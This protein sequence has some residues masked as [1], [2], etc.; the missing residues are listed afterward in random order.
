MLRAKEKE[1]IAKLQELNAKQQELSAVHLDV[2]AKELL[3]HAK[4]QELDAKQEE[5]SAKDS[6]LAAKEATVDDLKDQ[7]TQVQQYRQVFVIGND[8]AL[9][10]CWK[11]R[12]IALF[13][14][15]GSLLSASLSEVCQSAS[16]SRESSLCSGRRHCLHWWGSC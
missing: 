5:I 3:L 9:L 13:H 1:H 6:I 2:A 16:G 10:L 14:P 7:L 11:I 8:S 12:G 4:Q 15:P